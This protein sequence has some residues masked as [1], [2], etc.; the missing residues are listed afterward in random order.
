[1]V[2]RRPRYEVERLAEQLI[3]QAGVTKPPIKVERL[4]KL[5]NYPIVYQRF[6]GDASG[7][8][9]LDDDGTITIG[10]N[11]YHPR[12]RQRF[13][14]AHEIGH[15]QL[16]LGRGKDKLFVDPPVRQL[17]RDAD[18]SLGE[19]PREV[20]AN[21]Y[22]AA[23]LMPRAFVATQ[24]QELIERQPRISIDRLVTTLADRFEVSSQAMRYRLVTLGI[25]EPD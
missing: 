3:E 17:F 10:I 18:A 7:T 15:A 23:L 22:A 5:L 12:V 8:V 16:H 4:A 20:Q 13:S 2:K 24:G 6:A 11:S 1:M 14:I 21:Q 19:D 25:L 9:L